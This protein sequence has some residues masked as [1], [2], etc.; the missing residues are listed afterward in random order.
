MMNII[1]G[2]AH[3][4][5]NVDIQEFM[6]LSVAAPSFAEALRGG[7]E[8][9]LALKSQLKAAGMT[10]AVGDEGGFAPDLPSNAAALDASLRA[11]QSAGFR[12]GARHLAGAGWGQFGVPCRRPLRAGGRGPAFQFRPVR[13]MAGRACSPVP[14]PVH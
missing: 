7:A 5:N 13:R 4:E 2:G 8:V 1:N 10:T 11:I 3:A 12:P 6:I 9:F 14:D